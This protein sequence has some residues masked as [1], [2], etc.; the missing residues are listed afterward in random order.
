MTVDPRSS[1][2]R[3]YHL[4]QTSACRSIDRAPM[5]AIAMIRPT[6]AGERVASVSSTSASQCI[7]SPSNPVFPPA[8]PVG[9][10]AV[11]CELI[12]YAGRSPTI[13]DP[14]FIQGVY[15]VSVCGKDI[16][17]TLT[18]SRLGDRHGI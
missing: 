3:W 10:G 16:C 13:F 15:H 4:P 12:A 17:E 1:L 6:P 2:P 14:P 8:A 9:T 5:T 18:M 11:S 7:V